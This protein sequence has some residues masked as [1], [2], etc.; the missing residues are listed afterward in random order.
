MKTQRVC[1]CVRYMW[2]RCATL[3]LSTEEALISLI[4][5]SE[6]LGLISHTDSL[7]TRAF[8]QF[9]NKK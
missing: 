4:L 9:Y 1:V 7:M 2:E 3:L 5:F 6:P 8:N